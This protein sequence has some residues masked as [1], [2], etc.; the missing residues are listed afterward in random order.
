MTPT[1]NVRSGQ[2]AQYLKFKEQRLGN[3]I[4]KSLDHRRRWFETW[5][6]NRLLEDYK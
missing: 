3:W 1:S 5:D 2:M 4:Y 6:D